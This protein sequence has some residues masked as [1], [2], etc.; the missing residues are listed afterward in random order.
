MNKM[1]IMRER[2]RERVR[3]REREFLAWIYVQQL[4]QWERGWGVRGG[5]EREGLLHCMDGCATST[6]LE[7]E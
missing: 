7:R 1:D 5:R 6:V 4:L 3:E 2:K